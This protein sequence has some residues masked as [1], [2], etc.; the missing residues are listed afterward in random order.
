MN[1]FEL[2]FLASPVGGLV[3]GISASADLGARHIAG[4]IVGG[5]AIGFALYFGVIG[6]GLLV[7]KIANRGMLQNAKRT[8]RA[9][10][11]MGALVLLPMMALPLLS[12]YVAFSA[13]T[14]FIR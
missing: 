7:E 13:V 9:G 6:F 2:N 14:L 4:S 5:I 8:D 10:A 1:V 11:I 12:G 3:G